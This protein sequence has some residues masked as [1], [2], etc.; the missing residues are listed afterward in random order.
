MKK[1]IAVISAVTLDGV[2]GEGNIIPWRL[3]ADVKHFKDITTGHTVVMGRGTWESLP[4]KFR[5]LPGR[6]NMVVTNTPNYLAEGAVVSRSIEQAIADAPTEKV[7]CIGGASIWY[8]AM[9][10]ADEAFISVVH[11][12]YPV[13]PGV[14]HLAEELLNIET[15]WP[16]L[17]L[18]SLIPFPGFDLQHW[19]SKQ[20]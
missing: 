16:N 17:R 14:T 19:V 5:P 3:P 20:E 11:D 18:G 10:F 8:H 9:H 15:K 2:Y 12:K 6:Y 1:Y 7:F 13:T 4:S